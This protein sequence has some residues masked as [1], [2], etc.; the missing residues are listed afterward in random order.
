MRKPSRANVLFLLLMLMVSALLP[1]QNALGQPASSRE[2]NMKA[3]ESVGPVYYVH[4]LGGDFPI[5]ATYEFFPTPHEA[6]AHFEFRSPA[7]PLIGTREGLSSRNVGSITIGSY[8]DYLK[9]YGK[10]YPKESAAQTMECYGLTIWVANATEPKLQ[11]L[12]YA[13]VFIHNNN[14]YI[15]IGAVN[16]DLWEKLLKRFGKTVKKPA[17]RDCL[18]QW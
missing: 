14:Q 12:G 5:P 13:S 15:E 7:I 11:R 18:I 4:V 9:R 1:I 8:R 17:G 10:S 6:P 16:G 3:I 2:E